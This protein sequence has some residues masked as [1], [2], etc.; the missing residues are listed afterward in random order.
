MASNAESSF[1]RWHYPI[2]DS[3]ET[4]QN[5]TQFGAAFRPQKQ[6]TRL[7]VATPRS[8]LTVG[9]PIQGVCFQKDLSPFIK[10]LSTQRLVK[11]DGRL[12]ID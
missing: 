6:T 8:R 1:S 7:R 3:R 12:V 5:G 9:E 11:L 4:V 2:T 10:E